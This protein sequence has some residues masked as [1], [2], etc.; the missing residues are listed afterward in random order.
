MMHLDTADLT[1]RLRAAGWALTAGVTVIGTLLEQ[2]DQEDPRRKGDVYNTDVDE[3]DY[4]HPT[5]GFCQR[6]GKWLRQ[7]TQDEADA[8]NRAL[9]EGEALELTAEA[10]H[11]VTAGEDGSVACPPHRDHRLDLPL[12]V[13]DWKADRWNFVGLQVEVNGPD[14]T[15]WGEATVWDV[16]YGTFPYQIDRDTGDVEYREVNPLREAIALDYAA[17]ALERAQDA[18]ER[19][20]DTARVQLMAAVNS[21]MAY[22]A[23]AQAITITPPA[24]TDTR[25]N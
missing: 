18:L 23:A 6:C 11:W 21:A 17:D 13:R 14:G 5:R 2:D 19:A 20:E 25:Q 16:E 8:Y 3:V 1:D 9:P 22:V 10:G 12:V 15:T 7:L 4:Q 24:D